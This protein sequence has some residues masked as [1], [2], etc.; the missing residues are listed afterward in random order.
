MRTFTLLLSLLH[1]FSLFA[2]FGVHVMRMSF[3]AAAESTNTRVF[4][5]SM[6]ESIALLLLS[7]GQILYLRRLF[8]DDKRGGFGGGGGFK[9]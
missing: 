4:T 3:F 1:G 9:I 8:S 2:L 6:I 7:I 5:W